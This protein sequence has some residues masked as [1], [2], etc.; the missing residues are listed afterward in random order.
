MNILEEALA[1]VS[2]DPGTGLFTRRKSGGRKREGD[3]AGYVR[4][5][6]YRVVFVS[7]K[8]RLAHRLAWLMTHGEWPPAEIDH[9]NG[10]PSDNRLCN[11]RLASRSENMRNVKGKKGWHWHA[12][13]NKWQA[14]IRVD[15]KRQYLGQYATE[16]EAKAAYQRAA[17]ELHGGFTSTVIE[18]APEPK[19]EAMPL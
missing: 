11:L 16:A 12:S 9:I 15:G 10:D 5:D 13:R 7:G 18:H 6:G 2:Y 17:V 1:A 3:S 8:W 14:L 19:Q 4:P